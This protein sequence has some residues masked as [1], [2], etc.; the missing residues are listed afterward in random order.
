MKKIKRA[1]FLLLAA[2]VA[3]IPFEEESAMQ[4]DRLFR[5]EATAYCETGNPCADGTWPVEGLTVAGKKKWIGK[6]IL[7]YEDAGGVAGELLMI[8]EIRDTGGHPKIK[9][10]K[11]VDIFMDSEEKAIN[12]GRRKVWVKLVDAEG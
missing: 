7:I 5:I 6:T 9:A 3:V 8:G 11:C 4:V 12:F 10:G 2:L 1:M